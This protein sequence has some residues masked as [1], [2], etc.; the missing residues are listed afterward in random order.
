MRGILITVNRHIPLLLL[1]LITLMISGGRLHAS[2]PI[3][4]NKGKAL[5][6]ID[7]R[8]EE[9]QS[10]KEELSQELV[11]LEA[12]IEETRQKLVH[13]AKSIQK[14]EKNL[15]QL[16][17]RIK[18]L[19]HQKIN[20]EEQLEEDRA[21][22]ADLILALQRIQR[23]PPEAL[24]AKPGAP[25][26]TAQSAMLLADII[27]ALKNHAD[28][29]KQ[30]LTLLSNLTKELKRDREEVLALSKS[31]KDEQQD[32]MALSK[33][34][35]RYFKK[36]LGDLEEREDSVNRIK[37]ESENLRQLVR[38]LEEDRKRQATRTS[39][40]NA[41][42]SQPK[43]ESMPTSLGARPSNKLIE[44]ALMPSTGAP[45]LPLSGIIQTRFSE[46]DAFGAPSQG[47]KIAARSGSLVVAPMGG[48]VRFA[49]E[50]RQYGNMVII[51]H[52]KDYHSLI[53][54]LEKIDTLVGQDVNAGE[55]IGTLRFGSQG[56]KS[57]L[58]YELRHKGRA[59]NPSKKF[60]ALR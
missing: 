53:A 14:N 5:S 59:V 12:E 34:R 29:L 38:N 16:E 55:P 13:V 3:P 36:T 17:E 33:K 9:E 32:L 57:S 27:P 23:V 45:Q 48:I 52:K 19:E 42:M 21:S 8:L 56:N 37:A 54:G 58:Y 30:N 15:G 31:L 43:P 2:A 4:K 7:K 35:E 28:D 1:M 51:E 47:I 49:G 60:A 46:E 44:R 18:D 22:I 26:E 6:S 39:V 24:F 50:F 20:I 11:N 40:R 10:K 41:V 25:Y